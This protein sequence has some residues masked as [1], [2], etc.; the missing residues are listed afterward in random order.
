MRRFAEFVT[1]AGDV[2]ALEE[3]ELTGHLFQQE[4]EV[5][6][7]RTLKAPR[8]WSDAAVQALA[9]L[10]DTPR[11][12]KTRARPGL[13]PF[14]GM[15]PHIAASKD[16]TLESG[17]DAA[18][19]R[20]TGSLAWATAR[21]GVFDSP[22]DAS[23]FR[24]ELAASLL[25][26][27]VIPAESIWRQG[28]A[29]WAYGDDV[30]TNA[31]R[32]AAIAV[33]TDTNST[34]QDL[35]RIREQ[36][37][38]SSV[39]D[40]GAR[41]THDR[42]TAIGDAVERCSGSNEDRF[43]PRRNAALA[44][45]MRTA[46]KDGVPETAV[47]RAL[48]LARQGLIDDSLSALC[49]DDVSTPESH[50]LQIAPDLAAA[51]NDDEAWSFG[52]TGG[53][54]RARRFWL[55]IARTAWA[56]G[57]PALSFH[58][59]PQAEGP[60]L[61]IN[62]PAFFDHQTGFRADLFSDAIA[63]WGTALI[64]GA[65]KKSASAGTLSLTGFAALLAQSGLAY[66]DDRGRAVS[67]AIARLATL[68]IRDI[69]AEHGAQAPGLGADIDLE[70][71]PDLY[72]GLK[73]QLAFGSERF[74]PRTALSRPGLLISVQTVDTGLQALMEG[75]SDGAQ[76]LTG[77]VSSS[78]L[79]FAEKHLR[80]CVKTGLQT[81]DVAAAQIEKI[82]EYAAGHGSLRGAPGLSFES[83]L[84]RG[85][86]PD[87]LERLEDSICE[88]ASVR[89][90]LNRW[91]LGDRACRDQ[92][93]LSSDVIESEGDSL[94]Y[95]AGYSDDDIDAADR[96]A[97]G[98]GTLD[99]APGLTASQRL[100]FGAPP[101]ASILRM[102]ASIEGQ[103]SGACEVAVELEGQATIDDV[104]ALMSLGADL[105]LR[106]LHISRISSGLLDLMPAINFDKGDYA[107]TPP[108]TERIVE[109]TI[110][111]V[112]E[113][114]A[115]R[116]KLP[117]RRKGYIQKATVGGHKVYLHTGEFDDGELGEIFIDH[118]R[119]RKLLR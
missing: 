5:G 11:P 1:A 13:K 32:P 21:H 70:L 45:A 98:T 115:A 28:G 84:E 62:L 10:L 82:E 117:D 7:T 37:L 63:Y 92:L 75:D 83:L 27:F 71:I 91:T 108:S 114:P 35:Q 96:Y 89:F 24:D 20:I 6:S 8:S 60:V 111:R 57:M 93:G 74:S 46:L 51:V 87:A 101:P 118:H 56:F 119:A 47:E 52:E 19:S 18:I 9:D 36:A 58:E 66:D 116:R 4:E 17:M 78:S 77:V 2:Y 97:Q 106:R 15:T 64:L 38:K 14:A 16:R 112:V 85:L 22:E 54:V 107:A 59:S 29:D 88:G 104:A 99:D 40:V 110:E 100:I 68:R 69:A 48:A 86:G 95:A 23:A 43:D 80:D 25:G 3:R 67:A 34:P 94:C 30:D 109:R 103:L 79:D 73:D 53:T 49:P 41:V 44:R 105:G 90:A 31:H 76:P 50:H 39:L 42:L 12:A 26:R 61:H 72:D 81:L 33:R 113:R 102:A 65:S 55:D